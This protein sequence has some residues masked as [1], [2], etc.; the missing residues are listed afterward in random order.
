MAKL[1]IFI[2]E[3]L[4]KEIVVDISDDESKYYEES[5]LAYEE[6]MRKYCNGEIVLTADDFTGLTQVMAQCEEFGEYG[7]WTEIYDRKYR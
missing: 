2:E 7:D 4:C 3:T 6:V 5:F 1:S